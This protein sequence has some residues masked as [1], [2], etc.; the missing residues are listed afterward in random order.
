MSIHSNRLRQPC[1]IFIFGDNRPPAASLSSLKSQYCS[2][3]ASSVDADSPERT[4]CRQSKLI[5]LGEWGALQT[6]LI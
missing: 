2:Q 3:E 4:Q 5:L 1:A 6:L